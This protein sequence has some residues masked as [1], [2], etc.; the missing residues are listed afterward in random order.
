[1]LLF[2]R[3]RP[4]ISLKCPQNVSVKLQLKIPHRSSIISFWKCLFWMENGNAVFK[5]V[6]LNANAAP[7]LFP[8]C[9]AITA[10]TSDNL[11]KNICL[12]LMSITLKSCV[13]KPYQLK[14]CCIVFSAHTSAARAQKAAVKCMCVLSF[15][16]C[17]I[18][19]KLSNTYKFS[20]NNT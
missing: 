6:S 9:C 13:L 11:P 1:M 19:L 15:L 8:E 2:T 18:M 14:F 10:R 20:K 12:V 17:L 4:N 16:S 7:A 3:C 5:H